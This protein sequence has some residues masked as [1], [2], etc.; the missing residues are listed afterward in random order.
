MNQKKLAVLGATG[1]I[2][3]QT[4][5]IISRYPERYRATVLSA[6]RR[7]D[8]LIELAATFRPRLA[9]IGDASLLPKLRS[10]LEPLG[11]EA[12]AGPEALCDCVIADDVDMVVT[13]TVGYSGLAPTLAAIRAG[14]DIALA[15]KETLVVAGEEDSKQS[16]VD[17]IKAQVEGAG[18]V[19]TDDQLDEIKKHITVKGELILTLGPSMTPATKF[20][21]QTLTLTMKSPEGS[22]IIKINLW[23]TKILGRETITVPAGTFD[24]LKVSYLQRTSA[25]G[26]IMKIYCTEWYAEGIGEVRSEMS[27]SKGGKP[28]GVSELK[29]ITRP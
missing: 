12:A 11:I 19:I 10:A 22:S 28:V 14:K 3:R 18:Q 29:S 16:I 6:G 26:N 2:G 24:C 15:N 8:D 23:E 17:M 5:D 27:D 21:N 9:V 13:A 7:V 1:S 25:G 20:K 4:L